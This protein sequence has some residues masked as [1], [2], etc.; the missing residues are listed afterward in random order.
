MCQSLVK[1]LLEACL[2]LP[3]RRSPATEKMDLGGT[4]ARAWWSC[5]WSFA[6][7]VSGC[8]QHQGGG[9]CWYRRIE[10]HVAPLDSASICLHGQYRLSSCL[11]LGMKEPGEAQDF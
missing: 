11:C 7:M 2:T 4:C 5:C 10:G 8:L 6:C 1:L 3:T 9:M